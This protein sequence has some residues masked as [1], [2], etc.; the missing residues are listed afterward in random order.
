MA[1]PA[2]AAQLEL[3]CGMPL[4]PSRATAFSEHAGNTLHYCKPWMQ[5]GFR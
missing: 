2:T 3:V 5:G 4:D 1:K